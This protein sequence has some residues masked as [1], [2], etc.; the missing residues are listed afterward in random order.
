MK[1]LGHDAIRSLHLGEHGAFAIRP[2]RFSLL[3]SGTLPH[4]CPFL[5]REPLGLLRAHLSLLCGFFRVLL[6]PARKVYSRLRSLTTR[7]L[8]GLL[9]RLATHEGIPAVTRAAWRLSAPGG[10][11]TSSL[12][13]VLKVPSVRIIPDEC[14]SQPETLIGVGPG[15][16]VLPRTPLWRSSSC[17][18]AP[19]QTAQALAVV[20]PDRWVLCFL[21]TGYRGV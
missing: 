1:P 8:I 2:L 14:R 5:G 16:Y 17:P 3:L 11:P 7:F 19:S 18:I 13:R 21:C 10:A 20:A 9:T 6:R 4:R 15:L 12:K